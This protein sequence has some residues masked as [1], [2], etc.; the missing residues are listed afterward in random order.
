MRL[1]DKVALITGASSEGIG[2]AIAVLFALEGAKVAIVGR[3]RSGLE[4]TFLQIE[5][6][7][8]EC[9]ILE[10]DV[11]LP[12]A[13]KQIVERTV[14]RFG[15]LD[16]LVNN[17]AIILRKRFI[18]VLPDEFDRLYMTNVRGYFFCAQAAA[19]EMIEQKKGKIIMVSSD[20]ALAG[21]PGISP[22][23]ATKGAVLSLTRAIA[24]ELLPYR[25]NVNAIIPGTVKTDIN[26]EKME[27]DPE[28]C[29]EAEKRCP[30][31]IGTVDDIAPAAVYLASEETNWMT[32]QSIVIAG[33]HLM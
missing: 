3:N 27:S 22:Y 10:A 25:I 18:D 12:E 23:A 24:K 32:G 7:G 26:R 4:R 31:G 1:K 17:A 21:I 30:L 5:R 20:S 19:R 16:I 28:Y 15:K 9:L 6:I 8:G 29:E 2:R 14:E 33:G 13:A 11:S